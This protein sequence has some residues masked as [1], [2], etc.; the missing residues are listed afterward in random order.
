MTK[1][2]NIKSGEKYD[3]YCGR[4]SIFGNPYEI[5]IDGNR[6]KVI[7]RYKK[8]FKFC[9][10]DKLFLNAVLK[11]KGKTL[12]CFCKDENIE[13]ACHCD[14]IKEYLDKNLV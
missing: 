5:G 3:V 7:E 4:G 6:E 12:G 11:L 8:W 10:K 14:V 13:I 9:I 1:V 2:V